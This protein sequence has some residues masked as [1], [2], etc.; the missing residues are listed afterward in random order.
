MTDYDTSK[1][2]QKK[3]QAFPDSFGEECPACGEPFDA[4]ASGGMIT[5]GCGATIDC[6]AWVRICTIPEPRDV[7][8]FFPSEVDMEGFTVVHK[9]EHIDI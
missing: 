7:W 8:G 2:S 6:V 5:D 3:R 9:D 1:M 4:G